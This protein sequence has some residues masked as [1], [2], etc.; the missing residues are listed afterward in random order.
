[1]MKNVLSEFSA[2]P[3][4]DSD[5]NKI[6]LLEEKLAKV[7]LNST[8]RRNQTFKNFTIRDFSAEYQ[9]VIIAKFFL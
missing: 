4:Q 1:M 2:K 9:G 7:T 8:E 6:Y 3:L 5:I